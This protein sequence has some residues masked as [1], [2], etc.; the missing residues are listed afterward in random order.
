ME[1]FPW[2]LWPGDEQ[3]SS[4]A[5]LDFLCHERLERG[6]LSATLSVKRY[7]LAA[8][9][10]YH[11]V[12]DFTCFVWIDQFIKGASKLDRLE[13][14]PSRKMPATRRHLLEA[15][16]RLD[17]G[18]RLG[19]A[20]WACLCLQ[21]FF[22][23]RANNAVA[24]DGARLY[25]PR[26][27]LLR[28]DVVFLSED[29]V[30]VELTASTASSIAYVEITVRSSKSDQGGRSYSRRLGRTGDPH[31]LCPVTALI[32]HLLGSPELPAAWPVAAW[33]AAAGGRARAAAVVQRS[34]I[35]QLLKVCGLALGENAADFGSHSLRIGG[36][37]A[38]YAMGKE[39]EYIRWFG[40]W[41]SPTFLIYC[42]VS[43]GASDDTAALMA[44]ANVVVSSARL[45]H[46][47]GKGASWRLGG[48]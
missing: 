4:M 18:S 11:G 1:G 6:N 38:L 31:G 34:H 37:T 17:L 40:N 22:M 45:D 42:R 35:A 24:P 14:G 23:L 30:A 8:L 13:R 41:A 2:Y 15:R 33:D 20:M 32:D 16:R 48:F 10:K 27:I 25:D 46:Q 43:E 21:Y 29:K 3:R 9:F 36:A 28:S 39:T 19:R 44:R 5:V 12:S 26:R 7:A 47:A